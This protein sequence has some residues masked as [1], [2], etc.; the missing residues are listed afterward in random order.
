ML[1]D[2]RPGD[3]L[4]NEEEKVYILKRD[5]HVAVRQR[6]E[7]R[8]GTLDEPW[9]MFGHHGPAE[10]RI[11]ELWHCASFVGK[12]YFAVVDGGRA[13]L[14]YPKSSDNLSITRIQLAIAIAVNSPDESLHRY[15]HMA[16]IVAEQE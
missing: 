14:P 16:G 6:H 11:F 15:L 13:L 1:L 2:S 12:Y 9:A 5:L 8:P 3:W 7:E 4:R 10:I